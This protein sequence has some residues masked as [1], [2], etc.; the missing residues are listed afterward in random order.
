MVDQA[1][2]TTSEVTRSRRTLWTPAADR[3]FLPDY[4]LHER[5]CCWKLCIFSGVL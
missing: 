1:V 5:S 2:A 3:L 4:R